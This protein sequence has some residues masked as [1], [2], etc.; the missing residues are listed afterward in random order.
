MCIAEM[1]DT[2]S[3]LVLVTKKGVNRE[4]EVS[5]GDAVDGDFFSPSDK[6]QL[7]PRHPAIGGLVGAARRTLRGAFTDSPS[8]GPTE[9]ARTVATVRG[10]VGLDSSIGSGGVLGELPA[11]IVF[12]DPRCIMVA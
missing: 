5:H 12:Y 3:P 8:P 1:F 9:R 7:I 10:H 11:V 2:R 6:S 4:V